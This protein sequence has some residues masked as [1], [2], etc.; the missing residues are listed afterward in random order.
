MAAFSASR[1]V[2]LAI[3]WITRLTR[4]ISSLRTLKA[5]I[6]SRLSFAR[7]LSWC[8]RLMDSTSSL[9]P[10]TLLRWASLAAPRACWLSCEVACSVAIIDSALL[11]IC[12]AASSWD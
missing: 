6:N 5:S 11:T 2:W 10:A 7:W 3:D 12:A 1:L 8:M 9:R 4:W